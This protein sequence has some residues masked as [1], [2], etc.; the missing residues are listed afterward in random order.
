MANKHKNMLNLIS[1]ITVRYHFI[2]ISLENIKKPGN[3]ELA[4]LKNNGN[5]YTLL[6]EV[7]WDYHLGT[8]CSIIY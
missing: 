8:P 2:L 7:N 6:V 3:T 1:K 4:G 5:P